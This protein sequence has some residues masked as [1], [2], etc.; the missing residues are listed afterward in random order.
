MS[1]VEILSLIVTAI[2]L[3]SFCLV[4]TFLFR[5]Y[6]LTNIEEVRS[7]V[8]D[9]ELIEIKGEEL[10]KKNRKHAKGLRI[11]GKITG[12][13][14]F[15]LVVVFFSMSLY[16][17]FFN[18]NLTFG[19]T[20]VIVISTGSM[21]EKNEDNDYLFENNLNNQFNAYDIIGITAYDNPEDVNLYDVV[22]YK[23][24]E[25]IIIVHR[26]IEIREVNGEKVFIT[27]GDSNNTSDTNFQ[28]R[29]YLTFDNIVGYYN[30]F[31]MELIGVFVIFLQ[32]NAGIITIVAIAY[33]LIMFDHYNSKLEEAINK[34]SDLLIKELKYNFN[35]NGTISTY[36]IERAIYSNKEYTFI[37]GEFFKE[38][39]VNFTEFEFAKSIEKANEEKTSENIKNPAKD[40]NFFQKTF[41]KVKKFFEK[42][43]KKE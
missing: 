39:D 16:A 3:I 1:N 34:R 9:K 33:C 22:A 38:G 35:E 10:K 24:E 40:G 41:A 19:D 11:A 21:S 2:C 25:D 17:R 15:G 29:N 23:N 20:G 18:N 6:Y 4:F 8:A 30:G 13:A 43:N 12:W 36:F 42:D 26:I 28:Y 27:R 32:S 14:I 5:H 31:R 37:N 7:G